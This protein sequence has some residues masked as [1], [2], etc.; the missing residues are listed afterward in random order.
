MKNKIT[1]LMTKLGVVCGLSRSDQSAPLTRQKRAIFCVL[2]LGLILAVLILGTSKSPSS[3]TE[4]DEHGEIGENIP[5]GPHGGRLFSSGDYR[6]EITIFEQGVA[7][8]FRVYTYLKDAPLDPASSMVSITLQRL[9]R[10]PQLITF[11]KENDYLKG[12]AEIVEPHSFKVGI[13]ARYLNNAQTPYQFAYEQVEAR[14]GMSDEQ[15]KQ[16]DVQ[17]LTAGPA[18][19]KNVLSLT[20]EIQLNADRTAHI[21]PRLVGIVES[22]L[23]NAGDRVTK[24]QLLAVISSQGLA[25]QRSELLAA[26][27]R[28]SLARSTYAREKL[29]WEQKVSAEQDYQLAQNEMLAAEIAVLNARQKLA[30]LEGK[31]ESKNSKETST[32]SSQTGTLTRYE[33][34]SPMDGMITDKHVTVGEV[35]TLESTLFVIADLSKVW[36]EINIPAKDLDRINIGQLA[37][38]KATD[39]AAESSGKLSYISAVINEQNRHATGRVVLNNPT[40]TWRAGLPVT[41]ELLTDEVQ[42]PVAVSADAIQTLR[43]WSVVFGRYG[44]QFEARPLEL[45]RSDGQMIEV[46]SGVNAGERYAAKNS[47]LIKADLGKSE[48]SHDH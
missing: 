36:A 34:R 31:S 33:I 14:T 27:K 3:V 45:G 13:S 12:N 5:R 18:R 37:R 4:Q 25:D 21:V 47:F 6:I 11:S 23:V 32:Q 19:I 8:Q 40:G 43:G 2:G 30:S 10:A 44:A 15:V 42:V 9:G 16:N 46:I 26:Q 35:P 28:L 24:G 20:G 29:L 17:I 22:V 41:I 7:P 1:S 48:A 39:F 38:I